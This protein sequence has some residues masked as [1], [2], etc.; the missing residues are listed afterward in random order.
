[1]LIA[2]SPRHLEL[3]LVRLLV[4][5]RQMHPVRLVLA[6]V[7]PD[8]LELRDCQVLDSEALTHALLDVVVLHD[9]AQVVRGEVMVGLDQDPVLPRIFYIVSLYYDVS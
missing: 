5:L 7:I 6:Y 4:H 3:E 9:D 2:L 1:M 8:Y